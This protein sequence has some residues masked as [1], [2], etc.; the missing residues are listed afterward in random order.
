M[1]RACDDCKDRRRCLTWAIMTRMQWVTS[2]AYDQL[3]GVL[4]VEHEYPEG[5]DVA[6]HLRELFQARRSGSPIEL[7]LVRLEPGQSG[8][9]PCNSLQ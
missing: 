6:R 4:T 3:N 5:V 9:K 2:V 7:K 8:G 1:N